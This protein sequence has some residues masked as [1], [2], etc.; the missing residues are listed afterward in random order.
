MADRSRVAGATGDGVVAPVTL[1]EALEHL[2]NMTRR[3]SVGP[4]DV[5]AIKR[6][7]AALDAVD[8]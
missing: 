8:S 1:A 5:R 7:I 4:Y 3:E 2:R 6:V